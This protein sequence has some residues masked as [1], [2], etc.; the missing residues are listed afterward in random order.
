M[1]VGRQY[2]S[3]AQYPEF[4]PRAFVQ[5]NGLIEF[6]CGKIPERM[7]AAA[8]RVIERNVSAGPYDSF[9]LRVA[10]RSDPESDYDIALLMQPDRL[11]GIEEF[12]HRR[13]C[14]VRT[15]LEKTRARRSPV[16][17]A[18][19]G[20]LRPRSGDDRSRPVRAVRTCERQL[21]ESLVSA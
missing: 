8:R 14:P 11:R 20:N 3:G 7:D 5:F 1:K 19:P 21:V 15:W 9:V 16:Y 17:P 6:R 13:E 12:A 18:D 10:V 2:L 4:D